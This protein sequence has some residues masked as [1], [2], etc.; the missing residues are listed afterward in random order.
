MRDYHAVPLHLEHSASCPPREDVMST[1]KVS[2]PFPFLPSPLPLLLSSSHLPHSPLPSPQA[3]R[4]NVWSDELCEDGC[5]LHWCHYGKVAP[6]C[7]KRMVATWDD[8]VPC[9]VRSHGCRGDGVAAAVYEMAADEYMKKVTVQDK[10]EMP[11]GEWASRRKRIIRQNKWRRKLAER[12]AAA[13]LAAPAVVSG[14]DVLD[15]SPQVTGQ[16][17]IT[18]ASSESSGKG[19]EML[20]RNG[21]PLL[22]L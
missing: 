9:S 13:A 1:W 6:C 7:V 18:T 11:E 21:S 22:R 10:A 20:P 2:H 17:V 16:D 5:F 15:S 8:R 3:E 4:W 12:K 19:A 14:A